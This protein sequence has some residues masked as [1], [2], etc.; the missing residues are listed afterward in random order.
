M[1]SFLDRDNITRFG[2][3]WNHADAIDPDNALP[4]RQNGHGQVNQ[5]MCDR[6]PGRGVKALSVNDAL[7]QLF[8]LVYVY[9]ESFLPLPCEIGR[10]KKTG[11]V[12]QI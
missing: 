2:A 1:C 12:I 9:L 3:I 8:K 10:I 4:D 6:A 11:D 7:H 5:V